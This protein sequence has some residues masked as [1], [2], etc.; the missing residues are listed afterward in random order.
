MAEEAGESTASAAIAVRLNRS[1]QSLGPA[2]ANLI[3]KGLI[4]VPQ[5]GRIAFTVPGFGQYIAR[6][7]A[8][9]RG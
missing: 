5:R 9:E 1:V 8:R 4:Y 6:E 3:S 2:R 7:M